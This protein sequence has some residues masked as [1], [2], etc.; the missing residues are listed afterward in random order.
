[1][2]SEVLVFPLYASE[3][4][5][6]DKLSYSPPYPYERGLDVVPDARRRHVPCACA[7]SLLQ[8]EAGS[9]YPA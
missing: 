7:L 8:A 1:M 9:S 2:G 6:P 5:Q 3:L 4:E